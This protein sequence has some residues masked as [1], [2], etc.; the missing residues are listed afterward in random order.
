M[1]MA[2][3]LS[4]KNFQVT[5]LSPVMSVDTFDVWLVTP[6]PA[7]PVYSSTFCSLCCNQNIWSAECSLSIVVTSQSA[8]QHVS[9]YTAIY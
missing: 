1:V 9:L 3:I 7:F 5:K 8:N 6:W 2:N 4:G